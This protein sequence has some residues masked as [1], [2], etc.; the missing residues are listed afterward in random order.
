MHLIVTTGP[1]GVPA[2]RYDAAHPARALVTSA[3]GAPCCCQPVPPNGC[4]CEAVPLVGCQSVEVPGSCCNWGTERRQTLAVTFSITYDKPSTVNNPFT[5]QATIAGRIDAVRTVVCV[6]D[7]EVETYTVS[8]FS[9]TGSATTST[10]RV[11][12]SSVNRDNF[13]PEW[14]TFEG[15]V[16][17]M[18]LNAGETCYTGATNRLL[19]FGSQ[20]RAFLIGEIEPVGPT[21]RY[22]VPDPVQNGFFYA[23]NAGACSISYENPRCDCPG[24]FTYIP[25]SG[26]PLQASFGVFGWTENPSYNWMGT[27]CECRRTTYT[28]GNQYD[29]QDQLERNFAGRIS[30]NGSYTHVVSDVVECVPDPCEQP[31]PLGI[32]EAFRVILGGGG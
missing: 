29:L 10:G 21:E 8:D 23:T 5:C 18:F 19:A 24:S 6:D 27:D 9:V 11:V 16:A 14:G 4:T 31:R 1:D 17:S 25:T 22:A 20:A 13:P 3:G 32:R 12:L 28:A 7:Q 2:L 26:L 30:I 15:F